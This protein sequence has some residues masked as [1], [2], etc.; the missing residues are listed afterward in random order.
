MVMEK[1]KVGYWDLENPTQL[2]DMAFYLY[3]KDNEEEY[4]TNGYI[5]MYSQKGF[6]GLYEEYKSK[7]P[8]VAKYYEKAQTQLRRSKINKIFVI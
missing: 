2:D 3:C 5:T 7:V 4:Y 1:L 6:N 8:I